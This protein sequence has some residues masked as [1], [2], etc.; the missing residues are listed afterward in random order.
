M[1]VGSL[2]VDDAFRRGWNFWLDDETSI[3]EKRV[4]SKRKAASFNIQ[5]IFHV[6]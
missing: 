4:Q 6:S 2:F 3:V 1:L 5:E